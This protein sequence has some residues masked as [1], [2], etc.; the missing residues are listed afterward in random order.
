MSKIGEYIRLQIVLPLAEKAKG[1]CA[2]KWLR[3]IERMNNWSPEQVQAWQEER[4]HALVEH[5]YN[6]TRYYRRIFDELGLKPSDIRSTEDLKKLPII[7]KEIAN[8][9]FDEIVPNNLSSFHYREGKTGGTTGEPMFYYCDEDTWGYVT[10]AKIYYWKHTSYRYGDAF[11]AMGSASLFAKKPSLVRRIYD[12]IRNE[13]PMNTVNLTDELCEKYIGIIKQKKIRFIYGYAA[14]IYIFTK[15]VAAHQIDLKQIEAVF[16]TSEALTDEYRELIARTYECKVVDCY[17]ARDAGITAYE[18]D[19]HY[20]EVGYNAIAE[21]ANEFEPNTGTLLSTNLLNYSFPLIRYQFGDEAE[22]EVSQKLPTIDQQLIDQKNT[23]KIISSYS[24]SERK[25]YNGQVIRR[26]IGRTSDVMRLENGH[27]MTATGFSMIMKEF[28][29]VAFTFNKTGVNEV[30]LT[31]QPVKGK[32]NETQEAEIR[33][34]IY[35]YIGKDAKLHI[36]YV[37]K[38][39]ASKNGKRRYFMINE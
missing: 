6:H 29:V 4:L 5:A 7:N 2:T 24:S 10:A 17:G 12:K 39:E 23:G 22:L 32:Y 19:Y 37:E 13:V 33:R 1:T 25:P 36:L 3:Q 8:A 31:I 20:Y 27:N 26:I 28:D 11:V 34:T 16:T 9:H 35:L 14:S 21:V 15:Y 30:T 18:T 38:F